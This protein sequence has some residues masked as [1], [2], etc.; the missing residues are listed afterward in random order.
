ML[1][2]GRDGPS[3]SVD[4]VGSPPVIEGVP[5]IAGG[6]D[7]GD[8]LTATAAPVTGTAPIVRTWQWTSNGVD[9]PGATNGTYTSQL[10]DDGTAIRVRQI[11]TNAE[12]SDDATSDPVSIVDVS[13]P[14]ITGLP[15][16]SGTTSLGDTLTFTAASVSGWPTPTRTWQV[17]RD[18]APVGSPQSGNTYVIVEADLGTD[19]T[20]VQTET[21]SEGT[22]TATSAATSIPSAPASATA[23][24]VRESSGNSEADIPLAVDGYV[25]E[26]A[27]TTHTGAASGF[28]TNWHDQSGNDNDAT[29]V[30]TTAQPRIVNAGTVDEALVFDGSNDFLSAGGRVTTG[31]VT[32]LFVST[33]VKSPPTTFVDGSLNRA[34]AG[35]YNN[36]ASLR[37]WA[38]V[39]HDNILHNNK[40]KVWLSV[41]GASLAKDYASSVTVFD[42]TW[43]HV[44]FLFSDGEL[45]L[46]IDGQLDALVD[47][48][49]DNAIA[50]LYNTSAPFTVGS[51]ANPTF[52]LPGSITDVRV[53]EG[54][55]ADTA[56]ANIAG[57]YAGTYEG[58]PVAW[59]KATE[60]AHSMRV[61]RSNDNAERNILIADGGYVDETDL[62]SHVGANSGFVTNWRDR[63]GLGNHAVQTTQVSQPRIVNAGT[64]DEALVFDGT[65]DFLTLTTPLSFAGEFTLAFWAKRNTTNTD[66]IV[67]GDVSTN[68]KFGFLANATQSFV[69]VVASGTGQAV[70][71][72]VTSTSWNHY[73]I[74]RN[75]SNK[76]DFFVNGVL[77]SRMFSDVAQSGSCEID[78]IG[79]DNV[80]S[81]FVGSVD[82][83]YA[84]NVALSEAQIA[85]LMNGTLPASGTV[86]YLVAKDVAP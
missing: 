22:D 9:I 79:M 35:E 2:P 70:N 20:V 31:S 84:A 72:G 12:G 26:T 51:I 74:T 27:L 52:Y 37:S 63:S 59:Y 53:Y 54:A 65:N 33:W 16:V 73:A 49:T 42:N 39:N 30:T 55:A 25:D 15:T 11:E 7:V 86:L 41:N 61:R 75:A 85:A 67:L 64:V 14:T 62:A 83:V 66:D 13:V 6:T 8:L 34:V 17:Y 44:A 56:A 29:Q 57:I 40:M 19:I 43:H 21:N 18:A 80:A 23:M 47:K 58:S 71:H 38:I 3:V 82:Q 60:I 69:R 5:A 45:T 36:S 4:P 24:R 78:I 1:L 76:V 77:V 48:A 28:V 81:Q 68:C 32:K 10:A 46:Y 50:S